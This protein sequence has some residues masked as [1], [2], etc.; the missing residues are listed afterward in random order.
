[1]NEIAAVVAGTFGV[2]IAADPLLY[3]AFT[4]GLVVAFLGVLPSA[5]TPGAGIGRSLRVGA[6]GALHAGGR[7]A[8]GRTLRG[9]EAGIAGVGPVTV[10]TEAAVALPTTGD[11]GVRVAA[12]GITRVAI[13]VS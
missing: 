7:R 12:A 1:M 3:G 9:L 8:H 6:T 5:D 4:L 13:G 11:L 10:I 2:A